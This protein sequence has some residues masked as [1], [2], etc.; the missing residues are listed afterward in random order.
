LLANAKALVF[1]GCY[2]GGTEADVWLSRGLDIL[3]SQLSEQI[4]PDGG[5]FELSPMYHA[6]VLEDVLDLVNVLRAYQ[7]DV[8]AAW[9]EYAACMQRWLLA[10]THPDG[11]IAFFNDAAFGVAPSVKELH[12]YVARLRLPI[13]QDERASITSLPA[14]GYV[15][16]LKGAA[17]LVCDCA[18]VGPDYLP[19]HAHA[20]TLSFELSLGGQR[21]FVNSGTSLYGSDIERQRQR[22]TAAHNTVVVD[23]LNSSEVWDGFR[24]AR[25]AKAVLHFA[26]GSSSDELMVVDASHDGYRR[27]PGRVEHRRRWKLGD[28]S[29]RIEDILVGKMNHAEA[30]FHV[31][32]AVRLASVSAFE[33]EL[34][35]PSSERVRMSF[36]NASLME[37]TEDTWHPEFGL[38]VRAQCIVARFAD[39]SLTTYINWGKS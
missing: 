36:D 12:D 22:G 28:G 17:Y 8:P 15:R 14:S 5:H 35:L 30:R 29:L 37:V 18:P 34:L 31:H 27:L 38:S 9:Y 20:D 26:G 16:A 39:H 1:A 21:V 11:E 3:E 32:P 24:V 19:G 7:M 6:I 10:M 23:G 25:R 2:F 13:P 33:I 4:R